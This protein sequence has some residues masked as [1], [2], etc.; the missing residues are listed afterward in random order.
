MQLKRR[1]RRDTQRIAEKIFKFRHHP[2]E[3][4]VDVRKSRA[5]VLNQRLDRPRRRLNTHIP[6]QS[7]R[8]LPAPKE[9]NYECTT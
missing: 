3:T 4:M 7:H 6:W 5:L 9:D 1:E 2:L 8:N